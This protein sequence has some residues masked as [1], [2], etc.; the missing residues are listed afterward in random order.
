MTSGEWH[1]ETLAVAAGRDERA[2]APLNV[3]PTFAS[4]FRDG[5]EYTYGRWGNPIWSAFES[6]VGLLEG[7]DV[8]AFASGQAATAAIIEGLPIGATVL[9][10]ADA[11]LG[12]RSFLADLAS[13]GRVRTRLVDMTD[14]AAAEAGLAGADLLWIETPTNPHLGI[15]DLARLVAS[16]STAG[17]PS[18]VD[19]T[20]A[21]P[22]LQRPLDHG[23]TAAVHSATKYLGGHSD[24]LMGAVATRDHDLFEQLRKRRT[25]HGAIP[26]SME[27]FLALRGLRTLPVRL[28]RAQ[29]TAQVLAERLLN[30]PRVDRVHYPGLPADPGHE[31]AG[32][33]MNGYGAMISFVVDD[34]T[35]ADRLAASFRLIVSGTSL[36]GVETTVD[37]RNRWPGEEHVAPGLLRL[38]VGL[39]HGDD[40]WNDIESGLDGLDRA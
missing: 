38:S 30:H 23:A 32:R 29:R 24:L 31:L 26:G 1:F 39:E 5:G 35:S 17:I 19:N 13:R 6:A 8:I 33:Q 3:P 40:L 21:T 12:T 14:S 7:G 11:Y 16:A 15:V 4:T 37:R 34:A 27:A 9:L 20:F 18:V 25:L 2:G 28:E 10:P 22:L 36:G